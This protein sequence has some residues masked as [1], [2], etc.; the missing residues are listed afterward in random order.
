[1]INARHFI[2]FLYAVYS[3]PIKFSAGQLFKSIFEGS[4][5]SQDKQISKICLCELVLSFALMF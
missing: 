3:R 4:T 5:G 2:D 1:M